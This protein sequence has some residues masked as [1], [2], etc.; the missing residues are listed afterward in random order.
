[1]LFIPLYC[2]SAT[3][4]VKLV[5]TVLVAFFI[6]NFGPDKVPDICVPVGANWTENRHIIGFYNVI[7]NEYITSDAL[8]LILEA[9]KPGNKD[10]PFFL[11]LDEMNLSHVERY[12]ADFLSAMES[13]EYISLHKSIDTTV[14]PNNIKVP[15]N[16]FVIGT[17][18]V[19]ETTYMFSPKVLD[20]ANVI[21][22]STVSARD[23]ML[24]ELDQDQ[25]TGNIEYL[26]NPLNEHNVVKSLSEFRIDNF[27]LYLKSVKTS[28]GNKLWDILSEEF[29]IFQE[30]LKTAGFDF[31]FR[32]IDEMLRFMYVA[33]LYDGENEIWDNWQRYFD[34]QIKQKMLPRIH[35]SQ[36]MLEDTLNELSKLCA[37]YPTS[38]AKIEEMKEVLYK[39]R[40][41]SFTN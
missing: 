30:I 28:E 15:K 34:T 37:E 20:R 25:L 40:Y 13:D 8:E 19:D 16:L 22:F 10:R 41:V 32:V 26:E 6:D 14:Y 39:Q 35:G 2:P 9:S 17:V 27:K 31:G 21:E 4:T 38:K 7:T 5:S 23:Y 12:F 18:N 36:R 33:W 24:N 3:Y 1:M 29:N 11:I